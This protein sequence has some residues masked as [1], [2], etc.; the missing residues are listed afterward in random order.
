MVVH[1]MG[2]LRAAG[3]ALLRLSLL[4]VGGLS[5]I[6]AI[7]FAIAFCVV[8]RAE[9]I[10]EIER[11]AVDC[12]LCTIPGVT[13]VKTSLSCGNRPTI[14]A[15]VTLASGV[16][17]SLFGLRSDSTLSSR[18]PF[19]IGVG[20]Y[21]PKF[22]RY[23]C[24]GIHSGAT[25]AHMSSLTLGTGVDLSLR[26]PF[27]RFFP[28][29]IASVHEIV[30]R[31]EELMEAMKS[32]PQCP[33]S[34]GLRDEQGNEY[35]YCRSLGRYGPEPLVPSSWSTSAPCTFQKHDHNSRRPLPN[36]AS[37]SAS[38]AVQGRWLLTE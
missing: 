5:I 22:A 4:I 36:E 27:S 3:S 21:V 18:P 28:T 32:L 2:R 10:H 1:F 13:S 7:L 33:D 26:G 6:A 8:M 37:L 17:L 19:V 14:L 9:W 23:G 38:A 35:R 25:G 11:E 20:G 24:F 12:S 15:D 16:V 34:I 31:H 30:S 29:P